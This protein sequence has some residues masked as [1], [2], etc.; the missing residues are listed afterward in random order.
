[1]IDDTEFVNQTINQI[2]TNIQKVNQYS[3][4][5]FFNYKLVYACK[6]F[7]VSSKAN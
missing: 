3:K 7:V 4:Y 6:L 2:K 5:L 1:M